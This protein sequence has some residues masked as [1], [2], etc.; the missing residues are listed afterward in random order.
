MLPGFA[1]LLGLGALCA[2][3]A[4]A[5]P[6]PAQVS[7]EWLQLYR[8]LQDADSETVLYDNCKSTIY[9]PVDYPPLTKEVADFSYREDTAR[10]GK[11][12]LVSWCDFA[13]FYE[14]SIAEAR[15]DYFRWR[16]KNEGIPFDNSTVW[17]HVAIGRFAL[18]KRSKNY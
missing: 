4:T 17:K 5:K 13:R 1:F 9:V 10:F 18:Q 2:S 12:V 8:F 11:N 3:A 7:K 6:R 16:C 15:Y 14:C